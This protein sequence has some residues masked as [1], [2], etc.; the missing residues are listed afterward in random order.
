MQRAVNAA[1]QCAD[2]R[3]RRWRGSACDRTFSPLAQLIAAD[4][5][6]IA[7]GHIARA[8]VADTGTP[9]LIQA[10]RLSMARPGF[11]STSAESLSA[12]LGFENLFRF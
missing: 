1:Q 6:D 3:R 8:D 7:R 11:L 9:R 10:Q 5:G 12:A 2:L 4:I